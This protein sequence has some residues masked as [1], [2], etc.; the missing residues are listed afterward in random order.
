M[1]CRDPGAI[2]RGDIVSKMLLPDSL[3]SPQGKG[4]LYVDGW[5]FSPPLG[6]MREL[7]LLLTIV[8][9]LP[10]DFE[11]MGRLLTNNNEAAF[12][13]QYLGLQEAVPSLP[14]EVVPVI[15]CHVMNHL[16]T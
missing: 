9:I 8:S 6:L 5:S 13:T 16:T 2:R 10:L 15:F 7:C 12:K 3:P 14:K 4:T 11:A 1:G